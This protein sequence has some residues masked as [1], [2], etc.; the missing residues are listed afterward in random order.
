[1]AF[2]FAELAGQY[3]QCQTF[4]APAEKTLPLIGRMCF[5][6]ESG[7]SFSASGTFGSTG[8]FVNGIGRT[9]S[10]FLGSGSSQSNIQ[11]QGIGVG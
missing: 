6:K 3:N 11:A 8:T 4:T 2:E 7:V 1:M 5:N 9:S 10:T